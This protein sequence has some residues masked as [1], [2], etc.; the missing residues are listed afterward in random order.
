MGIQGKQ[1]NGIPGDR[2]L[3]VYI[4][5]VSESGTLRYA[6][7]NV[8]KIISISHSMTQKHRQKFSRSCPK[9]TEAMVQLSLINYKGSLFDRGEFPA[10]H[11]YYTSDK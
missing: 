2:K 8:Q 4:P 1:R 7:W 9:N 11:K 10:Y 3:I 5:V 6:N